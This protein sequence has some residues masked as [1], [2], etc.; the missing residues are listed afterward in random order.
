MSN[1]F[2]SI[3]HRNTVC[4]FTSKARV[5]AILFHLWSDF[6]EHYYAV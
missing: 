6:E 1:N 3:A 5:L 4:T 2:R